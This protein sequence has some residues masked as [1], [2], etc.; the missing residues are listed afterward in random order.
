MSAKSKCPKFRMTFYRW[1]FRVC[2]LKYCMVI[3][4]NWPRLYCERYGLRK[5]Y[6]IGRWSLRFPPRRM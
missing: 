3:D 4:H 2:A 5:V 6:R 1:G